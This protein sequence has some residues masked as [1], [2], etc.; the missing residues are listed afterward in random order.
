MFKNGISFYI[1]LGSKVGIW[2]IYFKIN[3]SFL[4][5][6]KLVFGQNHKHVVE[7][8]KDTNIFHTYIIPFIQYNKSQISRLHRPSTLI[9]YS[10]QGSLLYIYEYIFIVAIGGPIIMMDSCKCQE[11]FSKAE[12]MFPSNFHT[13]GTAQNQY[14]PVY[15]CSLL[16]TYYNYD[17]HYIHLYPQKTFFFLG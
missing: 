10:K 13:S 14:I 1:I 12:P 9:F 7:G 15:D 2:N 5:L 6:V 4:F 11:I 17:L 8:T 16:F 3:S